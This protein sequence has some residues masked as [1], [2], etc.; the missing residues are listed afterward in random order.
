MEKAIENGI[1][2][3]NKQTESAS[4]DDFV[5]G[6]NNLFVGIS[7]L[8]GAGK[9][10]LAKAL[11]DEMGLPVHYE[12]VEKNSYL[13]DFY[14]DP[15]RYSFPLQLALLSERFSAQQQIVWGEKGGVQ[16]RTIYEDIAFA[17][18]L[19]KAGHMDKRD[20]RTYLKIFDQMARS[21]RHNTLIVHLDVSPDVALER[22]AMRNREFEKGITV[23]YLACLRDAYEELINRLSKSVPVF[24]I[25]W[26]KFG[27]SKIVARVI[28][29]EYK[30]LSN[31]KH[32]TIDEQKLP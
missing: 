29:E 2:C 25:D 9:S 15:Q 5:F 31:V 18:V 26:S 4:G 32:I 3:S 28:A 1:H 17:Y 12:P 27:D 11:G 6:E 22:I 19:Y 10:T 30:K 7:G 16:D 8:I 21:M 23:D 20:Y 24:R 13:I 14:K